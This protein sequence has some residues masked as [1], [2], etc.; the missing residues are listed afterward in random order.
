MRILITGATGFLGYHVVKQALAQGHDVLCLKRKTSKN[1]FNDVEN[2]RITWFDFED[3][4]YKEIV[5]RFAPEILVHGAWGGVNAADRNDEQLQIK[6]VE[7][8]MFITR[9]Y[10]YKQ[11][12][13]MGSQDEY[14]PIDEIVEETHILNPITQYGK[15][16]IEYC[17][18]LTEYCKNNQIEMHWLR[19]FNMYGTKQASNWIIPAVM[20]RCLNGE[21][22]MDTTK[23]EQK[24]AYLYAEDFGKAVVSMFGVKGVS[25]IYNISS[26][27]PISLKE[28]FNMI[29]KLTNSSIKF[30]YGAIPYRLG[31][32]M[33]ICGNAAKFKHTFGEF[34]NV[35]LEQGLKF[36][37]KYLN[38]NES[39]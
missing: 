5:A 37:I 25:G 34:E 21:K 7:F 23:G 18:L 32:S 16:K 15:K 39:F 19:I 26:S 11:I 13:S 3:K 12:I 30:N 17:K 24:Y 22:E 6:N 38:D 8:S 35:S 9:L 1:P 31:Q 29:K 20:N 28:L 2:K 27:N 14:G 33:M 4:D 36:L 10:P